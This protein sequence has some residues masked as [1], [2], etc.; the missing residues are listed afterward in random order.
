LSPRDLGQA[1]RPESKIILGAAVIDDVLGLLV[2]A[3]VTALVVTGSI[4]LTN[5][6][7][8]TL[9]AV[10]FL[11]GSIGIGMWVNPRIVRNLARLELKN[12][13]LLFGSGLL[14][15]SPGLPLW[16]AWQP[17]SAPSRPD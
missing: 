3:V 11:V 10:A 16:Q 1:N 2:L 8:I 15:C 12:M 9:K 4:H 7:G 14:F 5:I 17:S 6:L 13:K